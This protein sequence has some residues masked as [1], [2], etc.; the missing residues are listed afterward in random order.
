MK[1]SL[2]G[3]QAKEVDRY[4]IQQIGI[5]SLVLMERAALAA[6]D[7]ACE[8]LSSESTDIPP[9][10]NACGTQVCWIACGSGNNGAD[11]IAMGRILQS[12]GMQ[13]VLILAGNEE[14]ASAEYRIQKQIAQR[15]DIQMA[16]LPELPEGW[17][18]LI[19]DALFGIGLTREIGGTYRSLIEWLMTK[20]EENART[21]VLAVDIPSGIHADTGAVMGIALKAEVTVTFGYAKNGLLLYP[22]R[23]YAGLVRIA[24]IGFAGCSLSQTKPDA[25]YLEAEDLA[26]LPERPAD[27]NKGTFG[28][29]LIISGCKGMSGAAY[30]SALAAYRTGAGLVKILTVDANRMILQSQIPEAIVAS[31]D[32]DQIDGSPEL[33]ERQCEWA[34]A[35]VLGPGLGREPYVE[36]LVRTVLE[37]AYVPIILDADALNTIAAYPQLTRY[38]TEN[39]ILTPHIGEMSRLMNLASEKIKEDRIRTAR[40]YSARTG[41]VCVLK[42]ASTVIADKDG[43]VY[44][45]TSGCCAMAKGGSGDVLTG[46]I[47]A[48]VAQGMDGIEAA[49]YGVYVHGLAGEKAAQEKGPR[50]VLAHDIADCIGG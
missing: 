48:L 31:Y 21:K 7:V 38:L 39:M 47:G 12:R 30:L 18:D 19:V 27:G 26:S 5:P 37:Y 2:T 46:V 35:I 23:G 20:K 43:R 15:L 28:K 45:N 4:T 11:G 8:L 24:D 13:I 40:E 50:G 17:P 14:H 36:I 3:A 29:V 25:R 34:D 1:N 10:S 9:L 16:V 6:A 42:D 33:I 49:A 32:P 44:I 22:G 41:A